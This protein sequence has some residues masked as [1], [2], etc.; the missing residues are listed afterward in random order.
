MILKNLK[1]IYIYLLTQSLY[2]TLRIYTFYMCSIIRLI[3]T[4]LVCTC[5][6][7]KYTN[8]GKS[9]YLPI[10][11][12]MYVSSRKVS[13]YKCQILL[14]CYNVHTHVPHVLYFALTTLKNIHQQHN[15]RE[16]KILVETNMGIV[17]L[18]CN[19]TNL[20]VDQTINVSRN[21]V[22]EL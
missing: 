16:R 20:I 19:C 13:I 3:I 22:E 1:N 4:P 6:L 18:R 14:L 5:Q 15:S 12:R 21:S 7:N 2:R 8:A 17:K 11:T 9:S 10:R